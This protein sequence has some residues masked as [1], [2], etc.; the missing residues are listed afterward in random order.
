MRSVFQEDVTVAKAIEKAWE[1]AGKPV[2]FTVRIHDIGERGFLGFSKKPAVISLLFDPKLQTVEETVVA[3][4]GIVTKKKKNLKGESERSK[5][6]KARRGTKSAMWDE[7]LLKDVEIWL[8]DI[9]SILRLKVSYKFQVTKK[10]LRINFLTSILPNSDDESS[11]ISSAI[12]LL[13]QFLKKKHKRKLDGY[14]ILTNNF[15]TNGSAK[16]KKK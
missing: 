13:M 2:E 16:N 7:E 14:Q 12:Y 5:M 1:S 9:F 8:N 11:F 10:M 3:S 15:S 4:K 6:G